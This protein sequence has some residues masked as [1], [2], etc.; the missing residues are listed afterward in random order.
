M[1]FR[2]YMY[3]YIYIYMY[4]IS[5]SVYTYIP[6]QKKTQFM[7]H[8]LH[9]RRKN[10]RHVSPA[11][12]HKKQISLSHIILTA[13]KL[14]NPPQPPW[15]HI[16]LPFIWAYFCSVCSI[17]KKLLKM[18]FHLW[19]SNL[20]SRSLIPLTIL[21]TNDCFKIASFPL[22]STS[23][24]PKPLPL[25][26]P[27]ALPGNIACKKFHGKN[28]PMSGPPFPLPLLKPGMLVLFWVTWQLQKILWW[29]GMPRKCKS[30]GL[31]LSASKKGAIQQERVPDWKASK[32]KA[33]HCNCWRLVKRFWAM[34]LQYS[35]HAILWK[36]M[37][38]TQAFGRIK[39]IETSSELLRQTRNSP[40][41]VVKIRKS[42]RQYSWMICNT[43]LARKCHFV[44]YFMNF[45]Q[46]AVRSAHRRTQCRLGPAIR[47]GW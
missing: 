38:Q 45:G 7:Y 5:P 23:E 21:L 28:P 13:M 17:P 15:N 43:T 39:L 29:Q 6:Q 34:L 44:T 47:R 33:Y 19:H 24:S 22:V 30:D 11:I 32:L 4:Q 3:I 36:K 10:I 42:F 12:F 37:P 41:P 1:L 26:F 2:S 35:K 27:F 46:G 8:A 18:S 31:Q 14:G 16:G 20:C 25:P 40:N 9:L